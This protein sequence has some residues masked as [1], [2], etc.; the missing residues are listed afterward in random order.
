M[1]LSDYDAVREK[2]ATV[3]QRLNST[4]NEIRDSRSYTSQGRRVEMAKAV[5]DAK[6]SVAKIRDQ[7]VADRNARRD[8]L[9]R[10]AFGM[11]GDVDSSTLIANR[12]ARD[13]AAQINSEEEAAAVLHDATQLNDSSLAAAVGLRA[14]NRGWTD[15]ATS[16]ANAWDKTA[17]LDMFDGIPNGKNTTAADAVV[18]RVAPPQELGG[19]VGDIDLENLANAEVA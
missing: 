15:V 2:V 9:E 13:R 7:H 18:F 11:V 17:Y 12:D 16:W 6:N 5:L 10:L 4:I 14:Y 3:Q 8:R 1:S 19:L